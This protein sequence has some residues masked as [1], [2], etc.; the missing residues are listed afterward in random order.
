MTQKT[1]LVV[2]TYDTKDDK[3]SYMA[4]RIE[5][6]GGAVKTM[7]VSVLGD[8]VRHVEQFVVFGVESSDYH[9]R[10]VSHLNPPFRSSCSLPQPPY[11]YAACFVVGRLSDPAG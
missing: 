7:D 9:Y 5:A 4:G 6:L 1:I 11:Q 8:P 2:G 10:F 3:L